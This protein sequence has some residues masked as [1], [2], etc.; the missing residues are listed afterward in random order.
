MNN[1]SLTKKAGLLGT[2]Q[3]SNKR[4]GIFVPEQKS[5]GEYIKER[6][7][8]RLKVS[9]IWINHKMVRKILNSYYSIENGTW[10]YDKY[11]L[12]QSSMIWLSKFLHNY[13]FIKNKHSN[14]N[15]KEPEEIRV[16]CKRFHSSF[17]QINLL[18]KLFLW[19]KNTSWKYVY[20]PPH[21]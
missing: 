2:V 10:L 1:N 11:R 14:K 6:R 21:R 9:S 15:E 5:T 18:K 12:L 8:N 7:S 4:R 17:H 19:S 20:F 13:N 16:R 3:V